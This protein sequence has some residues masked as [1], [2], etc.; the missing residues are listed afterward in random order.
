MKTIRTV[1]GEVVPEAQGQVLMHEH[2]VVGWNGAELDPAAEQDWDA[3]LERVAAD[4][5]RLREQH[6]VTLIVDAGPPDL[7][8]DV[9][10]QARLAQ[11]SGVAVVASTG[12]YKQW[13]GLPYYFSTLDDEEMD[14]FLRTELVDGVRDTGI[15]CGMIKLG[16]GGAS[17]SELELKAFRSGARV[18]RELDFPIITHTDPEGWAEANVGLRQ[19]EVLLEAG[20]RAERIG[21]G[22]VCGTANLEWL[23]EICRRGA[24]VAFDRVGM[25]HRRSDEVRAA[26]I[27]GLVAAGFGEQVL[28]SHDHQ[29]VW[30]RRGAGAPASGSFEHVHS[31][32]LPLLRRMGLGDAVIQALMR[33]NPLRLLAG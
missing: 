5:R 32:F 7:G 29:A 13:P 2:V 1:L 16:S 23:M 11:A 15:R 10:F 19:L 33:E 8:R 24:F 12:W 30:R 17:L 18:A 22:H 4:F 3:E 31:S 26:L 25:L 9:R 20:A 21:I 6:G 14:D 28:V 27:A